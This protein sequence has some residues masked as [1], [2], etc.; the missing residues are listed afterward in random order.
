MPSCFFGRSWILFFG[1]DT[2]LVSKQPRFNS[3]DDVHGGLEVKKGMIDV[4]EASEYIGTALSRAGAMETQKRLGLF[5]CE[6]HVVHLSIFLASICSKVRRQKRGHTIEKTML[7]GLLVSVADHVEARRLDTVSWRKSRYID[8]PTV[9]CKSRARRV[10]H[11]LKSECIEMVAKD[12]DVKDVGHLLTSKR[13][14]GKRASAHSSLSKRSSKDW[15]WDYSYQYMMSSRNIFK[16]HEGNL[17]FTA[18]DGQVG[19]EKTSFTLIRS[20]SASVVCWL[21]VSVPLASRIQE[22]TP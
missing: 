17:I 6:C 15:D 10:S 7:A 20:Q 16:Q 5:G 4:H 8:Q 11:A 18:D 21:P 2:T 22:T 12:K 9:F 14:F 19:G 3:M 1:K 13:I